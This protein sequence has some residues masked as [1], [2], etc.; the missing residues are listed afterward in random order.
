MDL[1]LLSGGFLVKRDSRI[2]IEESL[3]VAVILI[4]LK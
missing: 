4:S 3:D 1:V 2:T